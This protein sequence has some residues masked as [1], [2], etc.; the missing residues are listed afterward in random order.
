MTSRLSGRWFHEGFGVQM[1]V[2]S[3]AVIGA[4]VV[5]QGFAY[6]A[7]ASGYR[8]IL[9]DVSDARLDQA[10][11]WIAR[12]LERA[13]ADGTL[14]A[15][16]RTTAATNLSTAHTVEDAIRGAD[17]IIE[18]LPDEMEMQIELFTILDK[19]A[20][21]NAIFASTGLLSITELA[22]VTFCADRCVGMRCS[23]SPAESKTIELVKGLETSSETIAAC[24][25]LARRL[26]K[27]VVVVNEHD[28]DKAREPERKLTHVQD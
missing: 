13:M 4:G 21:P 2:K 25:D 9:E 8:T 22:E 24:T 18:T 23:G 19:F 17:L 15:I 7:A 27:V 26:G 14:E 3:V 20:K 11:V 5:G 16:A 1:E 10:T 12:S 28:A 6:L